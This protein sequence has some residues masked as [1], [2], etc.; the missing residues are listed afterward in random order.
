MP[1]T[2]DGQPEPITISLVAHHTFC[3]RRAW[4]EA[5]GEQTDTHQMEVR[6]RG[7]RR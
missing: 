5:T 2:D 7:H 4:L 6:L 3:L 1:D